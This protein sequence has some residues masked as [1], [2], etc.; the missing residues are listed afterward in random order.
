[1]YLLDESLQWLTFY[2][3]TKKNTS[4]LVKNP[5]DIDH[6][7]ALSEF[8][9]LCRSLRKLQEK[10]VNDQEIQWIL[11]TGEETFA[12]PENLRFYLAAKNASDPHY[13]GHAIKFWN[14]VYNWADAGY[15]LSKGSLDKLMQKFNSDEACDKGT[16]NK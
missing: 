3:L 2:R 10:T 15:V 5:V 16:E 8:G 11:V 14:V 12:I 7:P 13:L 4:S 9:L 1:M 6:L